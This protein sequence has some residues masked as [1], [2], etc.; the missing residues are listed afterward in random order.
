MK[1]KFTFLAFMLCSTIFCANSQLPLPIRTIGGEKYYYYEV[2]NKETIYSISNK[3]GISKEAIIRYNPDAAEGLEKEQLLFFPVIDFIDSSNASSDIPR[4]FAHTVEKGETLYGIS[5]TYGIT[6][7]DII[8]YN[9]EA[10]SGIREGEILQIPQISDSENDNEYYTVEAAPQDTA[11]V[12]VTVRYGDTLYSMA[13]RYNTSIDKILELN[14]GVSPQNFKAGEVIRVRPNAI[15]HIETE[16]T[17]TEFYTYKVKRGDTFLSLSKR[18]DVDIDE[19]RAANPNMDEPKKGEFI[20]IPVKK[21]E[22]VLIDPN[23]TYMRDTLSYNDSPIIQEMYDSIHVIKDDNAINVALM[24][25]FMLDTK[26]P[27]TQAR[28]YTE[29]YKGFLLAVDTISQTTD[30]EINIYAFDTKDDMS[31]LES[32]LADEAI[33]EMDM[34]FTPDDN[35][36]ITRLAQ[37]GAENKIAIINSFSLKNESYNDYPTV[38]QINTPQN[39]LYAKVFDMFDNTFRG[40]EVIFLHLDSE[41]EK[42]MIPQLK[43]HLSAKGINHKTIGIT[44]AALMPETLDIELEPGKK[45]VIIPTSGTRNMLVKIFDAIKSVK[46][47]RFDVDLCMMGYPEWVTYLPDFTQY[48][49]QIDTYIYSRFYENTNNSDTQDFERKYHKWYGEY[50]IYAAPKFGLLGYDTG[51]YFLEMFAENKDFNFNPKYAGLQ[52]SFDFGRV[53]NWSGFINKSAY[54]IHFTVY[55]TIETVVR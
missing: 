11:I 17:V 55:N 47:D 50:M 28:L 39:Y 4:T 35:E 13:K 14:P 40:C 7:D 1:W 49:N 30:K 53:S 12:Y 42:D 51:Y 8:K 3:L 31:T 24:L 36:Q 38:F 46:F 18:F 25:P 23:S 19:L 44:T 29:F 43:A 15:T 9:P 33:K 2:K 54:F 52:N 45:Y 6:P 22:T 16:R 27:S 41:N 5:K 21:N 48:F 34:I 20:Y 37:F 10:A 32:I 26:K